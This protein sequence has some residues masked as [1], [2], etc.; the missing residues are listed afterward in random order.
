MWKWKRI[1]IIDLVYSFPTHFTLMIHSFK[2]TNH[3]HLIKC[4]QILD[5][6]KNCFRTRKPIGFF[7]NKTKKSASSTQAA[8]INSTSGVEK[9]TNC[10]AAYGVNRTFGF[11]NTLDYFFDLFWWFWWFFWW[12]FIPKYPSWSISWKRLVIEV[13]I[14]DLGF[15]SIFHFETKSHFSQLKSPQHF[16][17]ALQITI[18]L[19][20]EGCLGD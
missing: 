10:E 13:S 18:V 9:S 3:T 4:Q 17:P 15:G 6:Y 16:Q 12:S 1:N 19:Y 2:K 8:Q 7:C 5:E 20:F 14:F 11:L